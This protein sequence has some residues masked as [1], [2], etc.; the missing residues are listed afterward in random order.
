MT[1]RVHQLSTGTFVAGAKTAAQS[2]TDCHSQ[3]IVVQFESQ[4]RHGN[5]IQPIT[6]MFRCHPNESG[7]IYWDCLL[8]QQIFVDAFTQWFVPICLHS[9]VGWLLAVLLAVAVAVDDAAVAAG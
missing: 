2:Q 4:R 3:T 5:G 8:L 9:F 7:L 6:G 1:L